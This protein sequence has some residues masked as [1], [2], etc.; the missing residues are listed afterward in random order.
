MIFCPSP[1]ITQVPGQLHKVAVLCLG[2]GSWQEETLQVVLQIALRNKTTLDLYLYAG[3]TWPNLSENETFLGIQYKRD[4]IL[5]PKVI[6]SVSLFHLGSCTNCCISGDLQD[7]FLS[8][9]LSICSRL[10]SVH[11]SVVSLFSF[12]LY[13]FSFTLSMFSF[14]P[15]PYFPS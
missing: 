6:S 11:A 8:P 3:N 13:M 14:P 7:P 5:S 15:F 10:L 12:T 9:F 2:L 1:I 4:I